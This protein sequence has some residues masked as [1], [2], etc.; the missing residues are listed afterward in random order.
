[1]KISH[2]CLC[3]PYTDGWNYQENLITKYQ[4]KNGYDVSI[5]ASQYEWGNEGKIIKNE[6]TEYVNNDNCKVYRLKIKE[7]KDINYKFKHFFNIYET[8][9]KISPDILFIHNVQFL[10]IKK[11]V[12]YAKKHSVKIFIDNHADFSNSGKN[13]LSKYILH[14]IIWKHMAKIIEPYTTKFYGVLPARV[15]FLKNIYKLPPEKCELLVMGADDE[16]IEKYSDKDTRKKEREN[17]KLYKDDFVIVTGG[18]IDK[19]KLQTL[20]LMEAVK[21]IENQK[22][23]LLIFGSVEEEIK[24]KFNSLCDGKKIQYLG[25]ANEEQ[26]YK[27]FSIADLVVFPGRHS[28]YWEQVVA[29]GIPMLC[30]HWAGTQHIDIGGNVRFL[31]EDSVKEIK[32]YFED[33]FFNKKVYKDMRYNAAKEEKCKFL[34]SEIAEK[35][36]SEDK[37]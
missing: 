3:G 34:Y 20:L 21:S 14:G 30:K 17:L 1:M 7:Q 23:K 6:S 24:T 22:I 31:K 19:A 27:Y 32:K 11:I 5:I 18:K 37:K 33:I 4:V 15:D 8:L 29:M 13:I 36:I 10:D 12:K 16:L 28:V 26:S 25:W 35:S 2:I 9:E